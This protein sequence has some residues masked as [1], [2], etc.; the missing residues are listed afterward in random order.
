MNCIAKLSKLNFLYEFI[1]EFLFSPDAM[2]VHY[3][4][5]AFYLFILM[6]QTY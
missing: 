4:M 2:E 3:I 5:I 1:L 6:Y